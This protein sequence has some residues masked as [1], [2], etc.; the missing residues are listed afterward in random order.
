[1][2]PLEIYLLRVIAGA[3]LGG[4]PTRDNVPDPPP[5]R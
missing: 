4:N 3:I 1:M 5:A 2:N